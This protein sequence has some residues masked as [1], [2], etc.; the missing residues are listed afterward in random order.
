[1]KRHLPKVV[2]AVSFAV[3]AFDVVEFDSSLGIEDLF[4]A[5][6]IEVEETK[7]VVDLELH[8]KRNQVEQRKVHLLV[9]LGDMYV[10]DSN[11]FEVGIEPL[12]KNT[13]KKKTQEEK[14]ESE[15]FLIRI[16]TSCN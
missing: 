1:M 6:E 16:G 13:G 2:D 15:R 3:A 11:L 10:E 14:L 7:I 12:E 9:E 8:K 5:L 4:V